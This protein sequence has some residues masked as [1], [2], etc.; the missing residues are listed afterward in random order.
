MIDPKPDYTA[1]RVCCVHVIENVLSLESR[2]EMPCLLSQTDFLHQR[3]VP[4]TEARPES[5]SVT[6]GNVTQLKAIRLSKIQRV[7]VCLRIFG[8]D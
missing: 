6:I 3:H 8:P 2:L 1:D 4:L 7:D 5:V